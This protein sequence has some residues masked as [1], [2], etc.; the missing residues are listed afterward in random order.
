MKRQDMLIYEYRGDYYF[1]ERSRQARD[2]EIC[3]SE[4][5]ALTSKLP[6]STDVGEIGNAV[7]KSL[8]NYDKVPPAYSPWEL[9][10]LRKQLCGWVGARSYTALVK[11]SRQVLVDKNYEKSKILV[12]PFD[13]HNIDSWET[14]LVRRAGR[15][16]VTASAADVGKAVVKA[17]SIATYH[18]DRRDPDLW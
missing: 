10:E 18:P 6:V 17:F 13:N 15:L 14:M 4:N 11:N 2:S 9:K 12:I 1:I 3:A 8:E 16:D 7:L 5:T